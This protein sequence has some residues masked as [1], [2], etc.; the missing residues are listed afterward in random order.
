MSNP[1]ALE[2]IQT[3]T[4]QL[5]HLPNEK[6]RAFITGIS[7]LLD[8]SIL[9]TDFKNS[10][11]KLLVPATQAVTVIFEETDPDWRVSNVLQMSDNRGEML[12]IF[13]WAARSGKNDRIVIARRENATR[14]RKD[15]L[16]LLELGEHINYV[17]Y[18]WH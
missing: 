15:E 9:L 5:L 14:F 12:L 8:G 2:H 1:R 11:V 10:R 16:S 6:E 18:N 3:F 17:C 7:V 4:L 13:E